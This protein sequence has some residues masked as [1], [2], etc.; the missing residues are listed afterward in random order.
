MTTLQLNAEIHSY[1]NYLAD[2]EDYLRKALEYLKKLSWQKRH[3]AKV[4]TTKKIHVDDGPLPTDK[5]MDFFSQTM[6]GDDEKMKEH[7]LS[8]KYEEYL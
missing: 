3:G 8:Q 5:F 1:L 7:Y 2:S 4:M 6:P